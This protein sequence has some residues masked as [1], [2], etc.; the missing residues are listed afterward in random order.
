GALADAIVRAIVA[1]RVRGLLARWT[2]GA[3]RWRLGFAEG[4]KR[5]IVWRVARDVMAAAPELVN[6]P[7]A[8]SWD[9]L[10]DDEADA[11]ELVPRRAADPRFAW[12][13]ADVPAASHPTIA[14]AL[15]RV[16]GVRPDDGVWDPFCGSASELVERARLGPYAW[17]VG[18][19]LDEQ[20]LV[21]ARANLAAAHVDATLALADAAAYACHP[22]ASLVIT[23]P[24]LG[25]RVQVDAAT[26]LVACLPSIVRQLGPGGR[27][28]W[29]TP[30]TRRTTPAA[31]A[32]GLVRT[33]DLGVDLGGVRGHLERWELP[34]S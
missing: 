25:S 15:A 5:A 28:V 26:L 23:N 32:L 13:V 29:I 14:A 1:P 2:R 34:S 18:S 4:H 7:T 10:V 11:L 30:A 27:L 16:A 20:A 12:R 17:L 24:P 31:E 9:I 3:I 21:A 8:T 33:V 22:A 6:D 19:D